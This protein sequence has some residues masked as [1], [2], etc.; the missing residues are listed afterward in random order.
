[1]AIKP[2]VADEKLKFVGASLSHLLKKGE[3][4]YLHI[5]NESIFVKDGYITYKE[6]D[7][8][9]VE[10]KMYQSYADGLIMRN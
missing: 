4:S 6:K 8:S 3:E 7:M 1:M 9:D 5:M 2:V 10:K